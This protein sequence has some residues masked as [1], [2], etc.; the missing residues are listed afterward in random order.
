MVQIFLEKVNS[1]GLKKIK[2]NNL[3]YS[4]WDDGLEIYSLFENKPYFHREDGP[5]IIFPIENVQEYYLN[6]KR[7]RIDGPAIESIY[8]VPYKRWFINDE[9]YTEEEF[10]LIKQCPWM[11]E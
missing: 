3:W 8:G 1:Y 9:E 10:D 5:A 2:I 4:K 7:H 11:I 6:D